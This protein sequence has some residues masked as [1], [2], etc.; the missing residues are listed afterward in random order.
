LFVRPTQRVLGELEQRFAEL[1]AGSEKL[2]EPTRIDLASEKPE[3]IRHPGAPTLILGLDRALLIPAQREELALILA[4]KGGQAIV[5]LSDVEPVH[6]LS[7]R[8]D[9][10]KNGNHQAMLEWARAL[11]PYQKIRTPEDPAWLESIVFSRIARR[12]LIVWQGQPGKREKV[13]SVHFGLIQRECSA[14]DELQR[15]GESLFDS[16]IEGA[17]PEEVI[18]LVKDAANAHFQTLWARCSDE[19][20]LVL[21]HLAHEGVVN[22]KQ[23]DVLSRLRRRHLVRSAPRFEIMS[24]SFRRF[25]LE[26][27]AIDDLSG[28]EKPF[29]ASLYSRVQGPV[30]G[31]AAVAIGLLVFTQEAAATMAIGAAGS[32]AGAMALLRRILDAM[33]KSASE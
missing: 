29:D 2:Q 1:R 19:E 10:G 26:Q 11:A 3:I 33:G 24:K 18:D 16:N 23:F 4:Q 20:K 15:I 27:D 31:I 12:A 21:V 17:R 6:F 13:H 7:G 14:S 28:K 22:P 30:V 25:V 9:P 5:V 32:I 8:S